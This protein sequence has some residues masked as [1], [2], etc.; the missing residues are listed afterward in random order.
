[1]PVL[2]PNR[3]VETPTAYDIDSIMQYTGVILK[4]DYMGRKVKEEIWTYEI[5]DGDAET[6]RAMY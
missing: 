2:V 3:V 1:V 6:V 4:K 5:S